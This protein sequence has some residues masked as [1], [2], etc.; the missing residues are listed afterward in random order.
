M[1]EIVEGTPTTNVLR[2]VGAL[3]PSKGIMQIGGAGAAGFTFGPG[4][5]LAIPA[6]GAASNKVAAILTGKQID[7]LKE[8][9]AKRSPAYAEAV[10][11]AAERW[12][13]AQSEFVNQPSPNRFAAYLSAS[14]AFSSG[15]MRDGIQVSS[16]DLLRAIQAPMKGAAEDEQPSVP[17]RPSQ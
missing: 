4:V 12:E 7:R 5:G 17:G 13:R 8:L 14:R 6:I 16:G 9:V 3:S 2:Q 15:L 1:R 10:K 11:K